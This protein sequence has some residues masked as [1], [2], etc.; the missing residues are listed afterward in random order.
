MRAHIAAAGRG[1]NRRA[2][3]GIACSKFRLCV[4][5]SVADNAE[6]R[7]RTLT[8]A[9]KVCAYVNAIAL[10]SMSRN[11]ARLGN[12]IDI[13]L[14]GALRSRS[15]LTGIARSIFNAREFHGHGG[16]GTGGR[17]GVVGVVLVWSGVVAVVRHV[18]GDVILPVT[19]GTLQAVHLAAKAEVAGICVIRDRLTGRWEAIAGE[20]VR[21]IAAQLPGIDLVE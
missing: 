5:S 2:R 19:G 18:T 14:H 10:A 21:K 7:H 3:G 13:E 12:F 6:L 20:K 17:C 1:E 16:Y 9:I 15:K 8:F 11:G 4:S